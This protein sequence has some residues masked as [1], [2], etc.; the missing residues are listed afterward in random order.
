MVTSKGR[1][2]R[3]ELGWLLTQEA[4]KA[5][6]RLREG[7]QVLRT[8]GPPPEASGVDSSLDALDDTMRLLSSLH[9]NAPNVRGRRGRIDLA[10][11]LW[12]VAPDVRVSIEPGS[13]T[14]VYGD[15]A[16]LRRVLHILIGPGN[17]GG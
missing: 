10:S 8:Q 9:Q 5:A 12:D 14:E 2:T 16:E 13:G 11:L 3:H 6:E 1:L 17:R 7:V 15:E 4:Q